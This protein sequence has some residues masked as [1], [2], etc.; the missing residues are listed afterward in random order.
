MS[1]IGEL[2]RSTREEKQL[3]LDE[4]VRETSIRKTYLEAVEN[5]DF[6]VIP[7][8]V[9][10]KGIIRTYG[11]FLGLDGERLVQEYRESHGE[12]VVSEAGASPLI[13]ESARVKVRPA[14]ESTREIGSGSGSHKKTLL[15]GLLAALVIFGAAAGGIWYYLHSSGGQ[16]SVSEPGVAAD[17]DASIPSAP[18]TGAVPEKAAGNPATLTNN[19]TAGRNNV[20]GLIAG[21]AAPAAGETRL[22][23]E[24]TGR[25]WLRVQDD[26]GRILY[27]GTLKR[28]EKQHFAARGAL[29]VNIGNLNDLTIEH[30]GR[31]LPYEK[32]REPVIRT[33]V[34]AGKDTK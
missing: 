11:N 2:L 15:L 32:T 5:N 24:S 9:F 1:D 7:G 10:V 12:A 8:E 33:Y 23:L 31:V 26:T 22:V 29:R 27:E 4:A 18:Q 16:P 21:T 25:C 19:G 3:S 17:K 34:P 13:R 6:A 20:T 30:N 28:G 14:F